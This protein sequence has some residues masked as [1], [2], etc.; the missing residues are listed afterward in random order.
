MTERPISTD[1]YRQLLED[2]WSH[3]ETLLNGYWCSGCDQCSA[4]GGGICADCQ[5]DKDAM[6]EY[7]RLLDELDGE[8]R[9]GSTAVIQKRS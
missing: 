2:A 4:S 5:R 3:R 8:A 6:D 7:Q 1:L 9:A